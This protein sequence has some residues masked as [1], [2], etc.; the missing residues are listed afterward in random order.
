MNPETEAPLV[1]FLQRNRRPLDEGAL[2][3]WFGQKRKI[4]SQA[5]PAEQEYL[6]SC[7]SS[8]GLFI[9]TLQPMTVAWTP[10]Q[11]PYRLLNA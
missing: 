7:Y 11:V 1:R 10:T 3:T 5:S 4:L 9:D 8:Y 2:R 6:R